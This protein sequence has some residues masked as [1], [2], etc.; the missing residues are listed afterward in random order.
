MAPSTN[1]TS[2]STPS[3]EL[4]SP[5]SS[6][7][8]SL[9]QEMKQQQQ[10]QQQPVFPIS[11]EYISFLNNNLASLTPQQVLSWALVSLPNV[12]Q[13][14]AFGLT[15]LVIRDMLHKLNLTV[16]LVFVDT[17]YHFEE[18]LDLAR[19]VEQKYNTPV[20]IYKP[21][22]TDTRQEFEAK[23]GEKLWEVDA[24]I[25]DYLVKVEPARRAVLD[26][27]AQ[28][29]ITG[30]RR[31]Q[32]ADRANIPILEIDNTVSP[33][34][35]KLNALASWDYNEVW[36]YIQQNEVPYNALVE[37][38]YKSIGDWHSTVPTAEGENE[39]EGR[40]K[41]QAKTECGL[42]KDYLKMRSSFIAAKKRKALAQSGGEANSATTTADSDLAP[43][44]DAVSVDAPASKAVKVDL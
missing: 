22:G 19:R 39:R 33:P 43:A 44:A 27:N 17:L 3:P 12:I 20:I 26:H 37:K 9:E 42:H 11:P 7:S 8:L 32:G 41:G 36:T 13:T 6:S 30:R 25:Y 1:S 35:L 38:G 5:S 14:T 34:L 29:T 15:G 31:S 2:S 28:V 4:P 23:H 10:Q 24:E 18:T 16:P 21:L 40:W